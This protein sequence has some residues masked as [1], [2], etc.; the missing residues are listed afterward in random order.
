MSIDIR[1]WMER[2]VR[3][4]LEKK[5][6]GLIVSDCMETIQ[7]DLEVFVRMARADTVASLARAIRTETREASY[8]DLAEELEK[9]L[10]YK[11]WE[12]D[13]E[14]F[15]MKAVGAPPTCAFC[16]SLGTTRTKEGIFHC[17]SVRCTN[18]Y[19]EM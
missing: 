2:R 10:D 12:A 16:P 9:I 14:A 15:L 5:C 8:G 1:D 3:P 4:H 19:R 11:V 6:D 18:K 7:Q 17:G 13:A